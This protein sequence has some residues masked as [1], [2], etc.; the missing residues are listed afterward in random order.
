M[1]GQLT[2]TSTNDILNTY[3]REHEAMIAG[4]V[5]LFCPYDDGL[6]VVQMIEAIEAASQSH[7]WMYI[8]KNN[9]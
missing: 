4:D 8:E 7:K 6:K 3:K 2:F 9:E 5:S 1:D